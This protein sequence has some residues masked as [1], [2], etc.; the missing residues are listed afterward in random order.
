MRRQ[1]ERAEAPYANVDLVLVSHIHGDHFNAELAAAHLQNNPMAR[2]ISSDQVTR[3]VLEKLGADSPAR[4]RVEAHTP[5]PGTTISLPRTD[6][7]IRL[8]GLPHGGRT[9]AEFRNLGHIVELGGVKILHVGDADMD[10]ALYAKFRLAEE[11]I[12]IALIPYWFMINEEGQRAIREHIRPKKIVAFHLAAGRE[13]E[14]TLQ[15]RG[16]FPDA[17]VFAKI[18]TTLTGT[19]SD[20]ALPGD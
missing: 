5:D 13:D 10:P 1:L 11:K 16:V 9:W 7:R 20:Q 14:L 8:L 3:A 4:R 12:D 6:A 2:L 15:V 19:G 18:G 17:E